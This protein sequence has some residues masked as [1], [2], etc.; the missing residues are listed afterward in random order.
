MT[1][2]EKIKSRGHW[3]TVIRPTRF[4]EKRIGE[5]DAL[6]PIVE[7]ASVHLR[8]WDFPHLD[9]HADLHIDIDWIG[10]ESEW[11]HHLETWRFHQSGQFVDVAGIRYDWP[12]QSDWLP[13]TE[14]REPGTVLG[15]ADT[16][17]RFTEVF[18]FA[19]RLALSEAGD[20]QMFIGV[21]VAGLR[22][23][24]LWVEDSRRAPMLGNY[25]ASIQEFPY[26]VVVQRTELVANSRELALLPVIQVFLR[27]GWRPSIELLREQQAEL[28]RS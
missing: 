23:R 14:P 12:D 22:G 5:I 27:F 25:K 6:Y 2:V 24:V 20:E 10:Q 26:E 13:R 1:L 28:R 16:L 8:G 9:R 11:Q 4:V 18:E 7:K 17:F 19:A 3:W 15:I 21:R